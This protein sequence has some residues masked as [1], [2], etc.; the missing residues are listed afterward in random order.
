MNS[1]EKISQLVIFLLMLFIFFILSFFFFQYPAENPFLF[2]FYISLG[3]WAVIFLDFTSAK[4]FVFLSF[5]LGLSGFFQGYERGLGGRIILFFELLAFWI[6]WQLIRRYKHHEEKEKLEGENALKK[7]DGESAQ[8]GKEIQSYSL[9]LQNLEAKINRFQVLSIAARDLGSTLEPNEIQNRLSQLLGACF[10]QSLGVAISLEP[11]EESRDP[12]SQWIGRRFMPLLITDL[13][14]DLRFPESATSSG[15]RSL[16]AAPLVVEKEIVGIARIEGKEPYLFESDDLRL[17]DYLTL[18]GS[19]SLWNAHLFSKVQE[20]S[21]TDTLTGL[22][23]HRFFQERLEEEILRAGRYHADL[24]ILLIDVDHFKKFNDTYG[25]PAGDEILKAIAGFIKQSVRV[26]DL[27]ARYGGEEFAVLLLQSGYQTSYNVAQ[28]IRQSIADASFSLGSQI[29]HL[30]VSIGL[31]AFP[32]E[33]T[34]ASQ[35]IRIADQRLYQAK[36]AGRNCVGGKV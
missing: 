24:G 30:S 34:I 4:F 32:E 20:L 27:L 12:F 7:L 10:P 3:L 16:L 36:A 6:I 13:E 8:L 26:T 21:I 2:L 35:L 28:R 17:L 5:L 22:Y 23:T 19:L 1:K 33:A 15:V 29:V 31:A 9:Q 25:H 11:F 14:K 18:V